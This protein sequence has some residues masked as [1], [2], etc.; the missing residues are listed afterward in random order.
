M[1]R[2]VAP[3]SVRVRMRDY[4]LRLAVDDSGAI[5]GGTLI[6]FRDTMRIVR[7]PDAPPISAALVAS[8]DTLFSRAD[9]QHDMALLMKIRNPH[10]VQ[11]LEQVTLGGVKQW[12]SIRGNDRDNPL[13]LFIHGGPGDA[14]MTRAGHFSGRGKITSPSCNGISAAAARTR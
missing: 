12:I 13:M 3:D 4:E 2:R 1:V 5:K 7:L 8:T 11:S 14:M 10:G 9:A 6:S